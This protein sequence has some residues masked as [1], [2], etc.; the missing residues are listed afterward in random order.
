MGNWLS[1]H[2][3]QS[4]FLKNMPLDKDMTG[5]G[6]PHSEGHGGKAGHKHEFGPQNETKEQRY[7]RATDRIST[8]KN[9]PPNTQNKTIS[10]G[11]GTS[12]GSANFSEALPK[13]SSIGFGTNYKKLN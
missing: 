1:K 13:G 8:L 12:S 10:F 11:M 7:K 9:N 3:Q 2:A 4:R 5:E 6:G